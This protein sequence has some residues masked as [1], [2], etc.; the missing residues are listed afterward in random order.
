MFKNYHI[1][2]FRDQHGVCRKLRLRGWLFA[3]ILLLAAL[4]VA[5]NVF[6]VKY[7]YNYKQMERDVTAKEKQATEQT[8]Q[9]LALSEKVKTLEADLTRLRGFDAK[10]R[11][12]VGLDKEPRDVSSDGAGDKDFEKKYL[13]LYR[14]EML[15]RKLHEFLGRLRET[16]SLERARQRELFDA[17][18]Q[19]GSLPASMPMSWPV[20]GWISSPFGERLSPFTG[21]KELHKGLDISAPIGTPVLAPA[22]GTVTF[23]GEA[24]DGGFAVTVDHGGG[25]TTSY[26]HLRDAEVAAGQ[27]VK[28]G[29]LIGHVGDLGQSTGPHLHYETRLGGVPVDPMRYILE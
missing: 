20:T 3:A 27:T 5:G 7:F 19:A 29:Q 22:D 8:T 2:V 6:L 28:R 26:S 15:T 25:L 17:L 14:Q 23:A 4:L 9:L 1:V 16:A 13:P 10:L 21:K 11:L 24:D 18:S 12:M